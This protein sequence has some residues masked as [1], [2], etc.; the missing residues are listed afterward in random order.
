TTR[1]GHVLGDARVARLRRVVTMSDAGYA[2]IL[3]FADVLARGRAPLPPGRIDA[4]GATLDCR[5]AI[6][7]QFTS[8]TKG[9]P[10]GATHTHRNVVNNARSIANVMRLTEADALC[11]PVPLYHCFGMVLSVLACVSAGAKMVFPGAAFEPGA[12]LAA[13]SDELCTALQGVPTIFI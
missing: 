12:T 7:I 3:S 11:I 8:G 5:D 9:S 13:V 2:G 4:I 1:A 6:N 10:K